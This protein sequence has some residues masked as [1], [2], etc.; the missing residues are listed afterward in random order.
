MSRVIDG[1]VRML[2]ALGIF[3]A[4]LLAQG[5]PSSKPVRIKVVVV[6]MF[7]RGEDTGDTPGSTNSGSSASTWIKSFLCQPR[8]TTC[9]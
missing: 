1:C 4:L 2:I 6:A 8:I 3:P 7:E 5:T 9:A